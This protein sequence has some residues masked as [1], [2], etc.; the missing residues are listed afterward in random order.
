MTVSV[1]G[2]VDVVAAAAAATTAAAAVALVTVRYSGYRSTAGRIKLSI[3]TAVAGFVV[4]ILFLKIRRDK[5]SYDT[6]NRIDNTEY[7]SYTA[8]KL[9]S[10]T[11]PVR[12]LPND[13]IHSLPRDAVPCDVN[14]GPMGWEICDHYPYVQPPQPAHV[15][16]AECFEDV[17]ASQP[18]HIGQ[19]YS[20]VEFYP[21]ARVHQYSQSLFD[22]LQTD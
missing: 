22:F 13:M 7:F 3:E 12:H 17:L 6:F 10:P 5:Y 4:T 1:A 9:P 16:P 14:D 2:V 18:P 15:P 11:A 21:Q 19:Y 20:H 8:N